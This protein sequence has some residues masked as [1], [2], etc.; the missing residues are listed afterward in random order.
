MDPPSVA[1]LAPQLDTE[2]LTVRATRGMIWSSLSLVTRQVTQLLVTI[3][4]MRLLEPGAF[5]LVEIAGIFNS[6][7]FIVTDLGISGAL[8]QRKDLDAEHLDSVY[9]L[10]IGVGAL[11]FLLVALVVSPLVAWLY[12]LPMLR[13]VMI[14]ASLPL[15]IGP[16]GG[17]Q[18][19]LV[20]RTLRFSRLAALE[21]AAALVGSAV[22]VGM[23]LSGYGVWSI[24]T[25]PVAGSLLGVL[26]AWRLTPWRPRLRFRWSAVRDLMR[27]GAGMMGF[28][29]VNYLGANIDFLVVGRTLGDSLLGL[30]TFAFDW[31]TIT[32]NRLTPFI[33]QVIFP[34]FSSVQDDDARLRRG[35][36]R[37][38]TY[39]SLISFPIM[40]GLI[41]VA[42]QF[43]AVI[44][45]KYLAA[46]TPLRILCLVGMIY[47]INTF[48]GSLIMSKGRTDLLF[49]ISWVRLFGFGVAVL[50]GVRFG[51]IGVALADL[52]YSSLTIWFFQWVAGRLIGLR[53]RDF[54]GAV[55]PS[56]LTALAMGLAT[57]AWKLWLARGLGLAAAPTLALTVA[58]G[59]LAT[60]GAAWLFRRREL[61]EL[62]GMLAQAALP[63]RRELRRRLAKAS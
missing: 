48:T 56:A 49:R 41:V 30:Y 13:P 47:S 39:T 15:L 51:L 63:Y 16:W 27:F 19:Q 7:I 20:Q 57:L 1:A 53:L 38:I 6:I 42:P 25:G 44:F 23:A 28:N 10:N 45:P 58:F 46:V 34:T 50:I 11:L 22:A 52:T 62:A 35:Y 55:L 17:P 36:L 5:G 24:V 8:V 14:V 4:L 18:R 2:G 31:G 40:A 60:L 12:R 29:L 3:I 59:G 54:A 9:W 43:V 26:I 32:Y 37:L 21:V 33:G 61:A